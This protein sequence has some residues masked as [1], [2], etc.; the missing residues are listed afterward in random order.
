M[1]TKGGD[2]CLGLDKLPEVS[3]LQELAEFLRVS[4]D[5]IRRLMRE[6]SLKGFKL[7]KDWRFEKEEVI[8]F[9][10]EKNK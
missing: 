8:K 2:I 7:G 9:L 10:R 3:T 1:Y 4:K 6:D 5:T